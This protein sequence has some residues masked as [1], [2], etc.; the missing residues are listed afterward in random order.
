MYLWNKADVRQLD[1]TRVNMKEEHVIIISNLWDFDFKKWI[2][3]QCPY[4]KQQS[5][6][7]ARNTG[8]PSNQNNIKANQM[9][10]LHLYSLCEVMQKYENN[11]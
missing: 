3:N 1:I 6:S 5:N 9:S 11:F 4:S 2:K 7:N 8:I 10:V